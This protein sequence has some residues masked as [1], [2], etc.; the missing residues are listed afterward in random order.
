MTN[1][2]PGRG[3]VLATFDILALYWST[4]DRPALSLGYQELLWKP[5]S[6]LTHLYQLLHSFFPPS[7]KASTLALA[8]TTSLRTVQ[9]L[10]TNINNIICIEQRSRHSGSVDTQSYPDFSFNICEYLK[11]SNPSEVLRE[12]SQHA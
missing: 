6:D 1:H 11:K 2:R 3:V 9:G 4:D 12:C 5:F 10:K 7:S 8:R